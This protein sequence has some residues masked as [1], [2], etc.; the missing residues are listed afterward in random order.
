VGRSPAA[1]PVDWAFGRHS[2]TVCPV[3][4]A[5]TDPCLAEFGAAACN[6]QVFHPADRFWLFQA[7]GTRWDGRFE[8]CPCHI[9][10]ELRKRDGC[11]V[12]RAR[13]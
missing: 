2:Q 7:M 9:N 6:L 10:G 8:S 1:E 3:H 13:S 4:P 11:V 5:A 12:C